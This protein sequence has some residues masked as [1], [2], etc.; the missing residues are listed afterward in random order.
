[1]CVVAVMYSCIIFVFGV[2]IN[3]DHALLSYGT[4]SRHLRGTPAMEPAMAA[5][6]LGGGGC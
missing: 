5:A 6:M 1:M 2:R 3:Y 4:A